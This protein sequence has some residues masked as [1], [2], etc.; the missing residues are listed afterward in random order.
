MRQEVVTSMNVNL[1]AVIHNYHEVCKHAAPATVFAVVKSEAYGHGSVPVSLA[2]QAIGCEH[3]AVAMVDEGI[4]LRRA[5]IKGEILIMGAT[6]PV[7][8]AAMAEHNLVPVLPDVERMQQW[9]SL[10]KSSGK[11]LKYHIKVDVGLGR[12][13]FMPEEG[14][15]AAS[16]AASLCDIELVGISSHLSYP[17][18][19]LELNELELQRYNTFADAFAWFPHVAKHLAASQAVARFKHMHMDIVRVGGL[20]Y[21]FQHITDSELDLK[22]AMEFKTVVAQVRDLPAGWHIGYNLARVLEKPMRIALLPMGWTDGLAS[23][24]IGKAQLLI[25]G[26]PCTLVGLCTDFAMV[27]ISGVPDVS[28]GDEVVLVGRQGEHAITAIELGKAGGISTGQLLGKVSVRV[29]RS[30]TLN[31]QEHDEL[32]ILRYI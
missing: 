3:F 30:Y 23:S 25:Q 24:Q 26:E 22:P 8:F 14:E 10:A 1:D 28:V 2:L 31:G 32:S 27:D 21:G 29:P 7:Q 9:A 18:G 15:L 5:G 12:M 20:L 4:Q 11:R 17:N 13:G 16:A 19:P 6:M